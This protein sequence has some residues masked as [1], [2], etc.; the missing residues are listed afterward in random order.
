MVVNITA[1]PNADKCQGVVLTESLNNTDFQVS[2]DDVDIAFVQKID[3][4]G[5]CIDGKLIF[6]EHVHRIFQKLGP[7]YLL[8]NV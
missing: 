2:L 7:R 4:L 8:Y 6:N 3:F 5:V 1:V